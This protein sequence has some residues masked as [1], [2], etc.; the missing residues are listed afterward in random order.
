MRRLRKCGH[1]G[2]YV[3]TVRGRFEGASGKF[4]RREG[5]GAR[6]PGQKVA[7]F[8]F[9][10]FSLLGCLSAVLLGGRVGLVSKCVIVLCCMYA[11]V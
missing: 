3:Q 4:W 2:V 1:F 10:R 9:G 7:D 6:H 8:K 11:W 5:T